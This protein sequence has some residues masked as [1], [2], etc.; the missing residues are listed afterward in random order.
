[1]C[2]GRTVSGLFTYASSI[3]H[4]ALKAKHW[5]GSASVDSRSTTAFKVRVTC[6]FDLASI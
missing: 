5:A 4:L 1:M 2:V 3:Y 6:H